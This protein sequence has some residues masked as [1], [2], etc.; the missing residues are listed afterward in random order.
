MLGYRGGEYTMAS[1]FGQVS[2][3]FGMDEV[4]CTGNEASILDCPHQ[5]EEDC[6]IAEGLGVICSNE[7]M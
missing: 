2:E 6:G 3:D 4:Y 5:T 7:G 1:Q